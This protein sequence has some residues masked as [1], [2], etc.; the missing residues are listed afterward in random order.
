MTAERSMTGPGL[1]L[2][3]GDH[4][5]RLARTLGIEGLQAITVQRDIALAHA[6]VL[7]EDDVS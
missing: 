3:H 1:E 6:N 4:A 5:I 7:T 2:C